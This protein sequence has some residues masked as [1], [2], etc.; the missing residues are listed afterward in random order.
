MVS[1]QSQN[2]RFSKMCAFLVCVSE[3]D[4]MI[5]AHKSI[6]PLNPLKTAGEKAGK[7]GGSWLISQHVGLVGEVEHHA[8]ARSQP[9][10]DHW[11]NSR[12]PDGP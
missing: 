9:S 5:N 4:I 1:A 7:N 6:Q 11:K 10:T 3:T 2:P 12:A 8:A